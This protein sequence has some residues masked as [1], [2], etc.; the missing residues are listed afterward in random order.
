MDSKAPRIRT[1]RQTLAPRL[2]PTPTEQE[3]QLL[4]SYV[5]ERITL[6]EANELLQ[7][8]GH[9]MVTICE[10]QIATD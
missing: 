2:A 10:Y 5:L 3:L 7:L 8:H 9:F 1:A 4:T 6:G